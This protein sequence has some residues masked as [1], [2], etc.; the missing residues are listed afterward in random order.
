MKCDAA[1][2][3]G[4]L[5]ADGLPATARPNTKS[6]EIQKDAVPTVREK[7]STG[8]SDAS[9]A[10]K[11]ARASSTDAARDCGSRCLA[12]VGPLKFEIMPFKFRWESERMPF[13]FPRRKRSAQ[14][15]SQSREGGPNSENRRPRCESKGEFRTQ[16]PSRFHAKLACLSK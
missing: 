7:K 6:V 4:R 9:S 16:S 14:V 15:Q 12:L 2:A 1:R 11:S 3:R 5:E 13:K 10:G 8:N